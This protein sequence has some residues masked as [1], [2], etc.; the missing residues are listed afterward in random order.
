MT[1]WL[2]LVLIAAVVVF[3]LSIVRSVK[4]GC[5][6]FAGCSF[7]AFVGS[8]G[9]FCCDLAPVGFLSLMVFR[10]RDARRFPVLFLHC[11]PHGGIVSFVR[12]PL[13]PIRARQDFG[14]GSIVVEAAN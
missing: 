9:P 3:L 12:I 10:V 11:L 4:H 13:S 1:V 2:Q 14:S 7:M 6:S 8:R 5:V